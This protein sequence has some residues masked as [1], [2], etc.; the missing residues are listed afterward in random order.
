MIACVAVS[1][2]LGRRVSAVRRRGRGADAVG[3][4]AVG[5][6]LAGAC[7]ALPRGSQGRA[8][9]WRRPRRCTPTWCSSRATRA[10]LEAFDTGGVAPPGRRRSATTCPGPVRRPRSGRSRGGHRAGAA[11]LAGRGPA[12]SGPTSGDGL[13]VPVS[14]TAAQIDTAFGVGL[15]Q[16]R[17]PRAG[18]C[19][20]PT[21]RRWCPSALAGDVDGVAGLDDLSRAG[22]RSWCA[23]ATGPAPGGEH[24]PTP[25]SGPAPR[26]GGPTAHRELCRRHAMPT[27]AAR[28]TAD[29]S[30]PG[31]LVLEP[32]PAAPRARGDR[33]HLRAR[34]LLAERHRHL[35]GLLHPAI[36]ASV[37]GDQRGRRRPQCRAPGR[38]R[39]PSTSRWW[40]G[41]APEGHLD[42]YV[43]PNGGT[44]PLDTYAAHGR[45]GR[46]PRS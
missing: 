31:V 21:P 43:G 22:A 46:S 27:E 7:P 39:R 15:E 34:A 29:R 19:R 3:A 16:Y 25:Q 30:G 35:R 23:R 5:A 24:G 36:T 45:P 33:R 13:I 42:V 37:N 11:W 32:L 8:P 4:G 40:S 18:W 17:L 38:A 26:A 2:S 9:A 10:A 12:P 6:Q 20:R 28:T 1:G 41:M 14:G 44:G